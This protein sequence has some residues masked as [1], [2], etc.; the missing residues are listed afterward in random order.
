LAG[1]A[2]MGAAQSTPLKPV[3]VRPQLCIFSKHLAKVP[4]TELG[5][6]AKQLGFE[7]VDL[8]VRPGG[9]VEP[10]QVHVDLLR[11]IETIRDEGMDVPMITTGLVSATEPWA[12]PILNIAGKSGV[13][14]FK[15][16]YWRYKPG[17]EIEGR[18]AQVRIDFAGLVQLGKHF[19]IAA[20]FHNHSGAYV[21]AAVWDIRTILSSLEPRWAGYYFDPGHATVE[22]GL[23]GWEISLRMVLRR[24]KMVALKDFYWEKR[25]GKW[26]VRWCPMGQ[27]MVN[28]PVVF[29]AFAEAEFSG[30]LS[31]HVEYEPANELDAISRDLGFL[32]QQVAGAYGS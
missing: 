13:P 15:P 26:E 28:W 27:G 23:G 11:A 18:V 24:M 5:G 10:Q 22:G 12:L 19:N 32:K 29:R 31:L 9:H 21:G 6:I 7:G 17:D 20:G 25:N 3:G 4:Y 1:A 2:P 16:G 14:Y 8:A 30:P